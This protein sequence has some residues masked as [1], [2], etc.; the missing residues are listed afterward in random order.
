MLKMMLKEIA[1]FFVLQLQEIVLLAYS[2]FNTLNINTL[3]RNTPEFQF[4][5]SSSGFSVLVP[6]FGNFNSQYRS[7]DSLKI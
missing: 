1:L 2:A 3:K 5:V 7:S 4:S 6:A